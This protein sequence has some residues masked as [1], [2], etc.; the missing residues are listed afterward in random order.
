MNVLKRPII[1][2]KMTALNKQGKYGFEVT[3]NA[4]KIEIKKEIEKMY[5]V[6]VADVCTM[7]VIGHTKSKSTKKGVTSGRTSTTK[8]AIVTLAEGEVLDIYAEI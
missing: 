8:K 6:K 4:N 5:G 1:T 2:E 7:R 3:L